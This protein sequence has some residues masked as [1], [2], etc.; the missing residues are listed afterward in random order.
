[1]CAFIT[2]RVYEGYNT[3]MDDIIEEIL[4]KEEFEDYYE[5]KRREQQKVKDDFDKIIAWINIPS[6]NDK[7]IN[8]FN[9]I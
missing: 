7:N 6:T 9:A 4:R 5:M 1:M 3:Y 2:T 8:E